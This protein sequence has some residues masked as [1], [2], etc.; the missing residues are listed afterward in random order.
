MDRFDRIFALHRILHGRRTPVSR[1]E[2]QE[3][4]ECS[5][6]TVGR[7][8][9]AARDYLGMPI[10]YDRERNGYCFDP[11]EQ[12]RYELPGLW[13]NASELFA[14]LTAQKLLREVQPGLLEP[15]LAPLRER[16]NAILHHRRAGHPRIDERIRI[17]QMAARS[18][19]LEHFQLVVTALLNRRQLRILYRSRARDELTEREVSP[20][21]LVYYRD[22]WYL[23]AWCHMRKGLRSFSLDR[24]EARLLLDTS[25]RTIPDEQLNAYYADAYGIFSG[26]ADKTAVLRFSKNMAKWVADEHWHSRQVG[27]VLPNGEY[28]LK[29]PYGNPTELI[30]DILKYGEEVEV[31]GPVELRR[32]VADKLRAAAERYAKVGGLKAPARAN[33][34]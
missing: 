15:H 21:R 6:A 31:L 3:K 22:N 19:R 11:E 34:T 4:L 26:P 12:S 17:L 25:A 8:I 9:E 10:R 18:T 13:F 7:L 2:L 1:R 28:D 33:K 30:M 32:A 24:M 5:R 23:D 14:L 27:T 29:V 16:I 20:Q